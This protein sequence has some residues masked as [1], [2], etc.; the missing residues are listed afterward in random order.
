M[1]QLGDSQNNS[2]KRGKARGWAVKSLEISKAPLNP[3]PNYAWSPRGRRLGE[4]SLTPDMLPYSK[5]HSALYRASSFP[6]ESLSQGV[7]C[8]SPE[9]GCR[10]SWQQGK[11]AAG[12]AA[13]APAHSSPL[14]PTPWGMFTSRERLCPSSSGSFPYATAQSW[15]QAG[16]SAGKSCPQ[17]AGAAE[18]HAPGLHCPRPPKQVGEL[19]RGW[20]EQALPLHPEDSA[21]GLQQAVSPAGG[22]AQDRS[23]FA[24]TRQFFGGWSRLHSCFQFSRG[25]E[26]LKKIQN[27]TSSH[28]ITISPAPKIWRG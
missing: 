28:S 8:S 24:I 6:Q 23:R 13:T 12:K 19:P 14:P 18:P 10:E 11:L 21:E 3:S 22:L 4:L 5:C 15:Q 26:E 7:P 16:P 25:V 17:P 9:E 20:M 27:N 2:M 1:L